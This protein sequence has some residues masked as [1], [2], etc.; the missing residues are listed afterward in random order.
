MYRNLRYFDNL[1]ANRRVYSDLENIEAI[2]ECLEFMCKNRK[3]YHFHDKMLVKGDV[4]LKQ[5]IT[6]VGTKPVRIKPH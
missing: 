6:R 1:I 2:G 4:R 3:K 5:F